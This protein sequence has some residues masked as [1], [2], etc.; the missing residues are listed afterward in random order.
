MDEERL[1][2]RWREL[3]AEL[4]TLRYCW[5]GHSEDAHVAQGESTL[6]EEC[7][8]ELAGWRGDIEPELLADD[9]RHPFQHAD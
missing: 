1:L 3:E 6:C 8:A 5:C 2:A 4:G 9:P 7:V